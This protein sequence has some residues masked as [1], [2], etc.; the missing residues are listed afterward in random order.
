[1]TE[2]TN[3]EI[4]AFNTASTL[5]NKPY[6]DNQKSFEEQNPVWEVTVGNR[7]FIRGA[8]GV[9]DTKWFQAGTKNGGQ[10]EVNGQSYEVKYK[11][12]NDQDLIDQVTK[13]FNDKYH[14]QYPIDLMVST[15]VAK[16]TV[17]L[18]KK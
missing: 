3:E 11:A 13:A 8:K 14:G 5:Q 2:W 1:M 4:N 9:Q 16:A 12:V 17:E 18:I 6:N 7:L 15:P 10:V